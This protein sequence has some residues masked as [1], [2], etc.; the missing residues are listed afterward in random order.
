MGIGEAVELGFPFTFY[1]G[2]MKEVVPAVDGYLSFDPNEEGADNTGDCPLPSAP[3]HGGGRGFTSTT[4][5]GRYR[6]VEA[7][8]TSISK[9]SPHPHSRCGVS[10]FSWV[11]MEPS[12]KTGEPTQDFQV[13][14][15]DTGDILVQIPDDDSEKFG[16]DETIGIQDEDARS[17]L[18][19]GCPD[20][21]T[22]TLDVALLFELFGANAAGQGG[23]NNAAA[24]AK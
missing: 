24:G 10:G 23:I 4:R 5:I 8:I 13:L 7:F 21:V 22:S 12:G 2:T 17:S 15:F 16:D 18:A 19:Y 11:G 20:T 9:R 14:L 3:S 1:E 6:R